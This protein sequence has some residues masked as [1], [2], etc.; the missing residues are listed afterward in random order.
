[1]ELSQRSEKA[2]DSPDRRWARI[3]GTTVAVITLTLPILMIVSRSPSNS[4]AQPLPET[5]RFVPNVPN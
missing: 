5:V 1:M 2:P 3:L 4:N